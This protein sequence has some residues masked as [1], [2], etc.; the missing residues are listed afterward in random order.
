MKLYELV[1]DI[2]K[3]IKPLRAWFTS[4]NMS[5]LFVEK[6]ILPLLAGNPDNRPVRQYD[7]EALQEEIKE[8]DIRFFCDYRAINLSEGKKTSIPFHTVDVEKLKKGE[9][10]FKDGIFHPK[11]IYLQG[12]DTDGELRSFIIT[13]SANLTVSGWGRNRECIA[14]REVN[15]RKNA[16]KIIDFYNTIAGKDIFSGK[17]YIDT[18]SWLDSLEDSA[19][20]EF[21]SGLDD[22]SFI[23]R[24][25]QKPSES[26]HI[27][28]PYFSNDIKQTLDRYI[29]KVKNSVN[30][31]PDN[32]LPGGKVR[33]AQNESNIELQKSNTISFL[34][35]K[36][37]QR[38]PGSGEQLFS[39]A[40]VWLTDS[41]IAIGSW[42]FT[43]A[44]ISGTNLEAGIISSVKSSEKK[45]LI[46]NLA[47]AE[48][49]EYMEQDEIEKEKIELN[50]WTCSCEVTADWKAFRYRIH[51]FDGVDP[52]SVSIFLPGLEGVTVSEFGIERSFFGTG[53]KNLLKDR[54]FHVRDNKGETV[55]T[56]VII[57]Q[58][59]QDRPGWEFENF[60]DLIF[61]WADCYPENK[62]EKHRPVSAHD[63]SAADE[64]GDID[65]A[66]N[67]SEPERI[68]SWYL[69]FL[70]MEN[71][72]KRIKENKDDID[73]LFGIAARIPG[74]VSQLVSHVKIFIDEKSGTEV[75][76]WY[77]ANETNSVVELLKRYAGKKKEFAGYRF[78][79][80]ENNI[81]PN[82]EPH[83][84]FIDYINKECNYA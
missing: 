40:K 35:D 37:V 19:Q 71:I 83:I 66:L 8:I 76:R 2:L 74:S 23:D 59:L 18:D 57:E 84:G 17:E 58:N 21:V 53:V 63:I 73:K 68:P 26:I 64:S 65:E 52:G 43:D 75:F 81:S 9:N 62:Y 4:F 82:L 13:G 79:S 3:D 29:T 48:T 39:H 15:D 77:L 28:S 80:I 70:S 32:S 38:M 31:I 27:W 50:N 61:A 47:S 72:R 46:E 34:N 5:P 1:N 14:V 55:Y 41:Q 45:R 33:I 78:E 16:E 56:G 49:I 7:Y 69:M 44:A 67:K 36:S 12:N 60:S 42:N 6:Y 30:L 51:N 11:V 24:L 20:W 22:I 10:S 25:L 54:L